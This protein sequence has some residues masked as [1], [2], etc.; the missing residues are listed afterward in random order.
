MR[1]ALEG[2]VVMD[3]AGI[4]LEFN[5]SARRI[6]GYTRE[7]VRGKLVA[8]RDPLDTVTQVGRAR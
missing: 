4:T 3:E 6:F 7:E 2:I 5:P 1:A 8:T